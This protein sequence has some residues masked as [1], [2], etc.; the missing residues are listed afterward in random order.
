MGVIERFKE[1]IESSG[2]TPTL[3]AESIEVAPATISHILNGRNKYP[4][5][6]VMIKLTNKYPAIDL[7]WLLTGA[8]E[9][10]VGVDL[11]NE[12]KTANEVLAIP[13]DAVGAEKATDVVM[14]PCAT[15]AGMQA[16]GMPNVVNSQKTII[17]IKV[18][19]DDNTYESFTPSKKI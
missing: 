7:T 17:E 1:I 4:S 8:N 6:E 16:V 5:A 18:F 10:Q 2:L 3:F 15:Q 14:L 9:R 12:G 13:G 19:Y 11:R